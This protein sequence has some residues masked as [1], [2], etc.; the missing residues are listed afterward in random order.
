[1]SI[2]ELKGIKILS[3]RLYICKIVNQEEENFPN[4]L[5]WRSNAVSLS[6]RC[7][8]TSHWTPSIYISLLD[9]PEKEFKVVL[10]TNTDIL[11]KET[12]GNSLFEKISIKREVYFILDI[13]MNRGYTSRLFAFAN[14]TTHIN[15][16]EKNIR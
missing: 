9:T 4:M 12:V 5:H 7:N 11:L 14:I 10:P 16:I 13:S 8:E 15:W 1:M 2:L 6:G 3:L